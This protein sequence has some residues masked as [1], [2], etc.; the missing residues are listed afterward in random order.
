[1]P[2]AKVTSGVPANK[3]KPKRNGHKE[4]PH[5]SYAPPA[6]DAEDLKKSM[7]GNQVKPED[8][9]SV[10]V[11]RETPKPKG[12]L[13]K[14][15]DATI[16]PVKIPALV[17]EKVYTRYDFNQAELLAIGQKAAQA[18]SR[19]TGLKNELKSI[20]SDFKSK[21]QGYETELSTATEQVNSGFE[22]REMECNVLYN[23]DAKPPFK[24]FYRVDNGVFVRKENMNVSDMTM[25]CEPWP[26]GKKLEAPW[27]PEPAKK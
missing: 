15:M 7:Q 23:R 26:V 24:A 16:P 3:R 6:L 19:I 1:M 20:T 2:K 5:Q 12:T 10:L 22:M 21:I 13:E 8:N 14:M 9:T 11:E 18:H 17:Q 27:F 25:L 4:Q